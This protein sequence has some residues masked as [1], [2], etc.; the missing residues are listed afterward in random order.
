[1]DQHREREDEGPDQLV[2]LRQER[3]HPR[4]ALPAALRVSAAGKVVGCESPCGVFDTD[5]YC[6]RAQWSSRAACNPA[7]WPVNYAAVFKKTQ[8]F[9]YSYVDDDATSTFTCAGECG[10]RITFGRSP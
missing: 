6:C 5:Q 8:P 1:V 9:A 3:V 7:K 4:R 2:R 10:Y